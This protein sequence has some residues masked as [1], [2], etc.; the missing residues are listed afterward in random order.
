MFD[1]KRTHGFNIYC[2]AMLM[3]LGS[4]LGVWMPAVNA[5]AKG[6]KIR[7]QPEIFNFG[8]LPE[9]YTVFYRYWVVN[10]GDDTLDIVDVKPQCGC[11]TVPLPSNRIAPADSMPLD[12]SFDSK[13]MK[14]VVNKLVRIW[15][16]DTTLYPA[17][18]YFTARVAEEP[19]SMA[20]TPAA[21][22]L[23]SIDKVEQTIRFENKSD[24]P[25]T[26][27]LLS[28]LP[29]YLSFEIPAD[30]IP[31]GSD[32]EA[33]VTVGEDAPLGRYETSLTLMLTGADTHP[34][35][36]PIRGIGFMR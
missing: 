29:D 35:T 17:I 31:P 28:P 1:G 24:R 15:S 14:G 34:V 5:H 21:V 32:I 10:D 20:L 11:T 27:Q 36:I 13:N 3:T 26:Y 23:E 33:L 22:H 9:G 6:P 12:L 25:Y 7:T 18:I 4:I 19:P 8:Y 16:N 2:L 30:T